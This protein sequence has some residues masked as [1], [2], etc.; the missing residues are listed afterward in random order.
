MR[1]SLAAAA[2]GVVSSLPGLSGF[3]GAAESGAPSAEG[4]AADAEASIA[5]AAS[6]AQE[7]LVA[8][9]RDLATGE[10]GI[11]NGTR[12]I[13]VRDPQLASRIFRAGR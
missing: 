8:H 4:A 5:E 9:V 12:E 6:S 11:F 10:I 1:S 3:V 7:P 2:A 13:V